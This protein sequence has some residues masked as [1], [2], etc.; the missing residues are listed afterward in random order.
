MARRATYFLDVHKSDSQRLLVSGGW[1][2][3]HPDEGAPPVGTTMALA[4][5]F[6]LMKYDV[7]LLAGEEAKVLEGQGITFDSARKTAQEAPITVITTR[8]GDE[9][10]FLRL[11]ALHKADQAPPQDMIDKISRK[12]R[13]ERE[14]TRL[15]VALSDWGWIAEREY[16][17]GK[18]DAVPDILLGSGWGAAVDGR[19][20][21]DGRCLWVRPYDKGRTLSE[22]RLASWPDHSRKPP[23]KS[24]DA[25]RTTSLPLGDQYVDNPDVSTLFQ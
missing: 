12:I 3:L 2:F 14:K 13:A 5:A 21:S 15:I 4:N 7:G 1:E 20:E 17:D 8:D 6:D 16:L 24:P 18:P 10:A 19:F 25:A 9:V 22:I 23:W 11:P